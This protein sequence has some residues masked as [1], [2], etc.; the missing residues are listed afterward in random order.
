M[1]KISIANIARVTKE[2]QTAIFQEEQNAGREYIDFIGYYEGDDGLLYSEWCDTRSGLVFVVQEPR[3][4]HFGLNDIPKDKAQEFA[5]LV[6]REGCAKASWSCDGRTRHNML[7]CQ[8]AN[9]FPQYRFD[10]DY[11]YK[12]IAYKV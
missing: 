4:V 11:N 6:E 2:E 10:I 12:C 3:A 8:L 1:D 5:K 9:M 7:S